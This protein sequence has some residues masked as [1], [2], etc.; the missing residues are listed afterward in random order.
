MDLIY[1]KLVG[2]AAAMD[3]KETEKNELLSEQ[4]IND[5]EAR[6]ES[7]DG[8]GRTVPKLDLARLGSQRGLARQ[9]GYTTAQDCGFCLAR[10]IAYTTYVSRQ[11]RQ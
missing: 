4:E 3:K 8:R 2:E 1:P 10:I 5:E 11:H 9:L 7:R 6:L